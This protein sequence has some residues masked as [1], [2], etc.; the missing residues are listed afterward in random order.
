MNLNSYQRQKMRGLIGMVSR[1]QDAIHAENDRRRKVAEILRDLRLKHTSALRELD[2]LEK[3][4]TFSHRE[5]WQGDIAQQRRHIAAVAEEMAVVEAEAVE[6]ENQISSLTADIAGARDVAEA[7][8]NRL[9]H[10]DPIRSINGGVRGTS[11][12]PTRLP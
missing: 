12:A 5:D 8:I 4:R 1:L 10:K 7:L 9:D 3:Q 11:I 6:V 2:R